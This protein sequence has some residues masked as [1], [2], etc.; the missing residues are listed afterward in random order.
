MVAGG[1]GVPVHDS[2]QWK[3]AAAEVRS[4]LVAV[5][6][7]IDA[8]DP[9][10]NAKA[11]PSNNNPPHVD[12]KDLFMF[13]MA[14]LEVTPEQAEFMYEAESVMH[15]LDTY[16]NITKNAVSKMRHQFIETAEECETQFSSFRTI[17]T[18]AQSAKFLLWVFKNKAAVHML[19]ELWK[20]TF[21]I[22]GGE[23]AATATEEG[24][25]DR[26]EQKKPK[27]AAPKG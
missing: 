9:F 8:L 18:P 17:L 16:I 21:P 19:D 12:P 15:E 10:K 5:G 2:Q 7:N 20:R 25:G 13:L 24:K 4:R 11:D 3:A 1:A 14:Y 27:A 23:D 22:T 26:D 6:G